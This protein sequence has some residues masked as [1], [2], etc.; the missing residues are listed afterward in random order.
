MVATSLHIKSP[1]QS[2]PQAYPSPRSGWAGSPSERR[3]TQAHQE[4]DDFQL[5]PA[6]RRPYLHMVFHALSLG[7]HGLVC[8]SF[9]IC[10]AG[11]CSHKFVG[12]K[13]DRG[14]E[15]RVWGCISAMISQ[16][17]ACLTHWSCFSLSDLCEFS[18]CSVGCTG[19]DTA[20]Q[21]TKGV[22]PRG[23]KNRIHKTETDWRRGGQGWG[24]EDS[25]RK[26][27]SMVGKDA[28]A[29]GWHR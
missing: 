20:S 19:L 7:V 23:R 22:W 12:E 27:V 17:S 16:A 25:G 5:E 4:L 29:G 18:A 21:G 24:L 6:V 1:E 11:R 8:L 26:V 14:E 9:L 10:Q 3:G 28:R 2:C 13:R 15:E